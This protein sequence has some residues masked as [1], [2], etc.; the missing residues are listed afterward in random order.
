[1]R[2]TSKNEFRSR[3][4]PDIS[5]FLSD[6]FTKSD[7]LDELDRAGVDTL[8]YREAGPAFQILIADN[9]DI[10]LYY[11]QPDSNLYQLLESFY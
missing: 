5:I 4:D 9:D 8:F 7:L 6:N 3:T 1:M 11:V 10:E 2:N